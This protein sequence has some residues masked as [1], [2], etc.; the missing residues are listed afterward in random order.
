MQ[1]V[2]K[3]LYYVG[4]RLGVDLEADLEESEEEVTQ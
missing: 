1:A 3:L 2:A 4:N